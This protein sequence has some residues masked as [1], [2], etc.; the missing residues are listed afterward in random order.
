VGL[1]VRN[2][3]NATF[4]NKISSIELIGGAKA[5]LCDGANLT[6]TCRNI[7][8]STAPL[9]PAINNKT[10]SFQIYVGSPP[11]IEPEAEPVGPVIDFIPPILIDV[12]PTTFSTG[13][14]D[15][16]Q[17]FNANLDNGAVGG[18]SGADIWFHAV[19]ASERYI[20]PRNGAR[21]AVGDGSNRGFAGCKKASFSSVGVPLADIPVGTYVC[22][23]TNENRISQF[24]VNGFAGTTMKLGYTTWAN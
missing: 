13:A 15:L 22:V 1:G 6:G 18:D 19:N 3:L 21:I 11:V 2:S 24:R 5:M 8:A 16:K 20:K 14:I 7:T 10:S 9:T 17:S 12:T 23:R 4:N